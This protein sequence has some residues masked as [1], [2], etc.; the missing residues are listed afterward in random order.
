MSSHANLVS[1][2]LPGFGGSDGLPN[3]GADEILNTI[4]SAIGTLKKRYLRLGENGERSQCILV[5]HDWGSAIA[6]RLAMET[7]GLVDHLVLIN[8]VV[9]QLFSK[10][11]RRSIEGCVSCLRKWRRKKSNVQALF[12]AREAIG[13]VL[14][15]LLKSNY[16]F[17]FTLPGFDTKRFGYIMDYLISVCHRAVRKNKTEAFE[18]L[19]WASSI[20]PGTSECGVSAPQDAYGSSVVERALQHPAGDWDSRLRLYREDLFAGNWTLQGAGDTDGVEQVHDAEGRTQ[21]TFQCPATILFGV[22]DFAL[23]YRICAKGVEDFFLRGKGK[24][25]LKSQVI[26]MDHCGHWSPLEKTGAQVLRDMLL[27]ITGVVPE[28]RKNL[29]DRTMIRRTDFE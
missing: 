25:S 18:D 17:M 11:I 28:G 3:Y 13:P 5:G 15:Q 8:G 23:D 1:L 7:Q 4:A 19:S 20:G 22:N 9:P 16:I 27:E 29:A 2:D 21:S 14:A 26:L 10:N 24:R 12:D 6:S